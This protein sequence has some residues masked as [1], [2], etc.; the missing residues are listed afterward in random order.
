MRKLYLASIELINEKR[1]Q[2][3]FQR[4]VV[5][6]KEDIDVMEKMKP[7]WLPVTAKRVNELHDHVARDAA[8]SKAAQWINQ[9]Y[10]VEMYVQHLEVA[11]VIDQ[12][13]NENESIVNKTFNDLPK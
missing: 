11:S 6:T 13:L 4:L 1:E 5:V 12:P 9:Q 10:P 2:F 8:Y 3:K 7:E